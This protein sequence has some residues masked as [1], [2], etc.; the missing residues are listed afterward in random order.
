VWAAALSWFGAAWPLRNVVAE[1]LSTSALVIAS[2]N[3]MLSTRARPFED[4]FG[5]LDKMYTSHRLNGLAVAVLVTSHFLVVPKTLPFAPSGLFG[6]TAISLILFSVLAAIAPRSPWRRLVPLR[7]QDWKLGHRFMGVIILIAAVH[8]MLVPT[9]F[10]RALPAVSLWVY[11]FTLLGLLAY[12]FRETIEPWLVHRHRYRV[13]EPRHVAPGVLE[14]VLEPVERPIGHRAGQFA[15]VRFEEGP[16]HE[17]HPFTISLPPAG[18]RLR[19]SV[20]ASG[21]YTRALQDHLSAGSTARVEGPYG[22]F[23]VRHARPRQLWLAGGIGITPFLALAPAIE[24]GHDVRLVWSVHTPA[25]AVYVDELERAA[26]GRPG[27]TLQVHDSA[28]MGRLRIAD[29]GLEDPGGLDV[30]VCGP[31]PMRKTFV[32]DL[33]SLGVERDRIFYEEFSLR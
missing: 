28:S 7:Y 2:T 25:E 12:V 21:D 16:S 14:I 32:A 5:G 24:P 29:L 4:A 11:G 13:A 18:G 30:L 10:S 31:V 15:F 17:Q 23:D 33:I 20:K 8:S 22:R 6:L 1:F 3:L 9:R 27:F 19:F 26:A